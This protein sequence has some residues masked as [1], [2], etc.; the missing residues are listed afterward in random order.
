M[1]R[2]ERTKRLIG[3]DS[4]T[5]LKESKVLIIGVGGVGSYAAEA[6]ARAGIGEITIMDGDNIALS[7][8]NRQ[9]VALQE[10]IGEY[11]AEVMG[12]RIKSINPD[13]K[14]IVIKNYYNL[15]FDINL[16]DYDY[17]IDAID[18]VKDK[19]DLIES[20]TVKGVKIISS[21]GTAGKIYNDSFKISDI[22]E[23]SVCP[24][25][26]KVRKELRNRG[27]DHLKVVY[28]TE[29]AKVNED[30]LG[31]MSYVP[32]VSGLMMAGEVIRE[33]GGI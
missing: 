8:I 3:S 32:G 11:K 22:S 24:L 30:G 6:I 9:L 23:T 15:E 5:K 26:K 10:N 14:V 29:K 19:L 1:E 27:I 7:N 12:K 4:L 20:C 18:S 13:A 31:T 25:A 33:L 2:F 21:M 28:S 16:A 17:V